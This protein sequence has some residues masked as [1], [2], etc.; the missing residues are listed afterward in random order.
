MC[1]AEYVECFKRKN[2]F[3][4]YKLTK[5]NAQLML[6]MMGYSQRLIEATNHYN[7]ERFGNVTEDGIEF[8]NRYGRNRASF[9]DYILDYDGSHPWAIYSPSDYNKIFYTITKS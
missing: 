5:A 1:K 2:C 7:E 6:D 8:G 4:A 3:H 9:G